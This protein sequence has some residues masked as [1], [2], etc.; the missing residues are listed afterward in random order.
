M[1]KDCF[2]FFGR[3]YCLDGIQMWFKNGLPHRDNDLPAIIR[4]DRK[5][6]RQ[7][8]LL[9]RDNDLPSII[10]DHDEYWYHRGKIYMKREK[11]PY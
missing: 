8:G 7:N 2:D 11:F 10:N 1:F 9:H 5:E 3:F 4:D 6:W